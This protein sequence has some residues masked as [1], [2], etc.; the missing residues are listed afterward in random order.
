VGKDPD[1][2]EIDAKA[3]VIDGGFGGS[4]APL[5]ALGERGIEI[6]AR[7]GYDL[8]ALRPC[9]LQRAALS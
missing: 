6:P 8:G 1:R 5:L 4:A 2:G 3:G 7:V 9:L